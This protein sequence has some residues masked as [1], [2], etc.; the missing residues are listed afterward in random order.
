MK[1][2][3]LVAA[4]A[5]LCLPNTACLTAM[6]RSP[7]GAQVVSEIVKGYQGRCTTNFTIA[8]G[9][10]A[11]G[12]ISGSCSPVQGGPPLPAAGTP[13][14]ATIPEG[15]FDPSL[16]PPMAAEPPAF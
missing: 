3:L 2:T 5:A 4:V 10:G 8:L 6:A 14:P 15:M 12:S 1:R 9:M 16:I 11:G 7:E 13:I